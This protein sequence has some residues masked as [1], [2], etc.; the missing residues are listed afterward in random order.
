MM[1]I[2]RILTEEKLT[3]PLILVIFRRFRKNTP[4][5]VC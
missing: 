5:R 2:T 1:A 3:G 4:I